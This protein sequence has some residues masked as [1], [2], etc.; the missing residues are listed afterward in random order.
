M[1]STHSIG[2][3]LGI[4]FGTTNSSI[5]FNGGNGEVELVSFPTGTATTESFRSVLYLEQ[6]RHASRTQIKGFTG[7]QAIEHYLRAEHKGQLIQ[8]LKSYLTSRTLT[9]TEVF[10]RRYT[11]E[12]LIARI[13]TDLRLS[14]E[15][16]LGRPVRQAT[17]G[18]PVRFVGS[19]SDEDDDFAVQ[20]LRQAFI[21]AGFESVE[22]EMEPIAA[23]YAYESTLDHDELILIGDFGGGTRDFSLVHVGPGVRARGRTAKDLLG[24][25]G[26]GLA[27]D[28]FDARIVRKLVSP[29]LGSDSFERSYA[30]APDRPASIIPAAP[31]WIYANLERWH[32]LS[33]LKTRNVAE[34][35]KSARAR[36]QEPE[37]IE[38][39]INLIE[40]DLGYQLHQ[41]VQRLKVDLSN[42][43]S[44][45]FRFRDGSMDLAATVE[46]AEFEGWIAEDLQAI[47]R[48]VDT[49]LA[50]SNI[51]AREV[52]RVFLTG[53][54]SFV[55]AVR[56][57]FESRF[58]S[59]RVRT[60][61]EFT[62]VARGLALRPEEVRVRGY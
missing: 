31:A 48:C 34:I 46:R 1:L 9:G 32:Y 6:Q 26:L 41:P 18:R 57:I 21:H 35:L 16:Q 54:T 33:F 38:A 17:V 44:A 27:G 58:S 56:R 40:E 14:A 13:L 59:S 61:N 20:R 42:H 19:E 52:D 22:F 8:S 30:H 50:T 12:D 5:A 62:S 10:G 39:L 3:T 51:S 24:N 36:A 29:A 4:D 37:K 28:A 2:P 11:I 49:L 43:E 60:G 25:S 55:P 45:K 23:A 15:R 7:P 53:G 47:E